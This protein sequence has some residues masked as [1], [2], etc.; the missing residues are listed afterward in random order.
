[1]ENIILIIE[2]LFS[3]SFKI[4]LFYKILKWQKFLFGFPFFILLFSCYR[5][6]ISK[7]FKLIPL[8]PKDIC[9]YSNNN[10]NRFNIISILEINNFNYEII[11]TTFI[12]KCI[13]NIKKLRL[14]LIYKFYKNKKI[15]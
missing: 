11:K 5:I 7:I 1:M 10:S 4:Y 15:S 9:F 14:K 8:T 13:K 2:D 3:T 12:N 6:L